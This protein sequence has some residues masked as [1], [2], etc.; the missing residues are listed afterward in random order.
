M[1]LKDF[2][3]QTILDVESALIESRKESTLVKVMPNYFGRS[4]ITS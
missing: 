2:I 1:E 3:K 4:A